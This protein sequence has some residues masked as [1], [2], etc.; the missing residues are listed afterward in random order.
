M[1]SKTTDGSS[2]FIVDNT[3]TDWKVAQYVLEW[4]GLSQSMDIATGFFE[5]GGFLSLKDEWQKVDKIRIL[6][7][8]EVSFRTKKAFV[9]GLN[10][11]QQR[12]DDSLESEKETNDFLTGVSAIVQ[13][14]R[15]G[16]I[17]CR[18]YRKDKFHAKAYITHARSRVVGS[19]A[20]VGSSNFT[21]PGLTQNVELNVQITGAQVTAL[22]EWFDRHW[23]E[24]EEVSE[25][26]FKVIERHIREYSPFE[27]YAKALHEFFRSHQETVD[28]WEKTK[29]KIY[30]ILATYQKDGYHDF[31]KKASVWG[32]ALLC[33]GVGLGKTFVGLMLIER[34][35]IKE[36]KRVALFV[37][38]AGRE[39]VWEATLL[40]RLPEL[41]GGF[42]SFKIFNHTDLLSKSKAHEMEQVRQQADVILI[43]EAHHFRNRGTRGE[44]EQE[45]LSRYWKMF[46]LCENK[47]VY[48]M[49]ATPVNN[50][51]S[52]FRHM[53][54]LFS[55]E[56]NDYFKRAPLGIHSLVSHFNVLENQLNRLSGR[57]NKDAAM[58]LDAFYTNDLFETDLL[59]KSL[60]V[61]RSRAYVKE[62]LRREGGEVLFPKPR[63]PQVIEYSVKQTYGKLLEMV[64]KAFSKNEPLFFL[65]M[66]YPY[67]HYTGDKSK[68]EA[69]EEGRLRV[70]VRLIRI[71]FLK[72]F[73][74]SVIA[75]E[76]SCWKLLK[77]MLAWV[78]VHA[79]TTH[80]KQ[81]LAKFKTKHA[82]LLNISND[83]SMDLFESNTDEE[84]EDNQLVP[85]EMLKAVEK[86]SRTEF[87]I[88]EILNETIADLDQIIDFVTELKKFKPSQ[89]KKLRALIQLL[90]KDPVLKDH[91]VLIFTEFMNTARYLKKQLIE[92]G[93]T[94]VDEIDSSYKGNRSSII[95]RFAPYYNNS[96]SK[97]LEE[98]KQEEIRIL[99]STDVL[100][101]GLNLQD[102]TRLINYDLHWNPVRLMQRIGR[103]DRRMDPKIE[104]RIIADHP[105]QTKLR[106]EVAY[107]NML[108][109]QELDEL[110]G[111][112]RRVAEKTLRISKTFGV[113]GKKLL[114]PDDEYDDLRDFM[115]T[116]EGH[117]SPV[118]QLQL[119][120][121]T[122][123]TQDASLE[124]RLQAFPLRVFSG[125]AHP[126]KNARAVFFCYARP[127]HDLEASAASKTE[128]WT[129]E[130]GDVAWY[131][132]DLVRDVI[133]EDSSEIAQFIRSTPATPR[134]TTMEQSSLK[135][136]REKMDKHLKNTYLKK[137][138]APIGVT[139]VLKCW[140]ELN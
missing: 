80:E 4:C 8:D 11:A 122:L 48:L 35:V 63:E 111:L 70:L 87:N 88:S 99:I 121:Q 92:E 1:T 95:K 96:S 90:K 103:V 14:I 115:E 7:G 83:P 105:D 114:R 109:P 97:E 69:F 106:G 49:T 22:Q 135:L 12:L 27:V 74:S 108:P 53:V 124:A 140:M 15:S 58:Q 61:Q 66:Y 81:R 57:T 100:S 6:M 55:R 31:L 33:D 20:L 134:V 28:E 82:D 72:R 113:E 139:P 110:L 3:E 138:Q 9:E 39:A 127:A 25:E 26:L 98:N 18:I 79:E 85:D 112:Y 129:L 13:G 68:I 24:A 75:F 102:C 40:Q 77:K 23:Q 10:R 76:S 42:Y 41:F 51:L 137:V 130:A 60:V 64:E 50:S 131:L 119:E 62:S 125:K 5:I 94:G 136:L 132:H 128:T 86:L 21:F 65:S 59:F 37:P 46:D 133:L 104:A 29:S 38:K 73:E 91:K 93:F 117:I 30:P 116:Y 45:R 17:E 107:W 101:E 52:D 78:E 118:E 44:N 71:G 120:L 89:D 67:G 32:G 2:L 34:L 54:E 123:L 19:A 56:Q 47:Q 84:E 126:S 16:K 36:N 43:D